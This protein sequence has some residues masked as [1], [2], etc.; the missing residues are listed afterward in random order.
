M[1]VDLDDKDGDLIRRVA[2]WISEPAARGL[3]RWTDLHGRGPAHI[4]DLPPAA[5]GVALM[6]MN[7]PL[8]RHMRERDE[9]RAQILTVGGILRDVACRA[10]HRIYTQPT[11]TPPLL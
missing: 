10:A 11:S 2:Y 9:L 1:T 8:A 6:A 5:Q 7:M 3:R 4:A